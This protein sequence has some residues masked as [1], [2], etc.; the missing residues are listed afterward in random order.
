MRSRIYALRLVRRAVIAL[1]LPALSLLTGLTA[2]GRALG[3]EIET[4]K[5]ADILATLR[6]E[7][8]LKGAGETLEVVAPRGGTASG[9][10]VVRGTGLADV[11]VGLTENGKHGGPPAG[12]WRIF[13]A[14]KREQP[15]LQGWE[16]RNARKGAERAG[17]DPDAVERAL[18]RAYEPYFDTL[19]E[20]PLEKASRHFLLPPEDLLPVV[21]RVEVP[22]SVKPGAYGYV[23]SAG[24]KT[25]PVTLRVGAFTAP[26]PRD[27]TAYSGFVW[28][29]MNLSEYYEVAPWS[30]AHWRLVER[31]FE[32]LAGVGNKPLVV[33]VLAGNYL[34]EEH[35]KVRFRKEGGRYVPDFTIVERYLDLY[36]KHMGEPRPLIVHLW[37]MSI[38]GLR[39][40]HSR[41]P[42]KPLDE[43]AVPISVIGPDGALTVEKVAPP[44]ASGPDGPW[45]ALVA[46]M[47]E[48]VK[49]RGWA[50][51][52]LVLGTASDQAPRAETV[53]AFEKMAPGVRWVM[54]G[55][56]YGTFFKEHAE[57]GYWEV[58]ESGAR[59]GQVVSTWA[60][61]LSWPREDG[62]IGGWG[63]KLI[64]H[65]SMRN[66]LSYY[67][68]VSQW[69]MLPD[70]ACVT[71][72]K[73]TDEE[74]KRKA[75]M[76]W[77]TGREVPS[78][79]GFDRI[80][81]DFWLPSG[82]HMI[83]LMRK[84][85]LY[86]SEPVF[87]GIVRA[88]AP[89]LIYAG[90]DGPVPTIRYEMLREGLQECEARITIEKALVQTPET[91][92]PELRETCVTLLKARLKTMTREGR[93][94]SGGGLGS[95]ADNMEWGVAENWRAQ[96]ARL[97]ELA[98]RVQ[99]LANPKT[100]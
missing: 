57:A 99:G 33:T 80:P 55:H 88:N 90:P 30:E 1:A 87:P 3:A 62:I 63:A 10:V 52:C 23:L 14:H 59:L 84:G 100:D 50:K 15:P 17:K 22:R 73:V 9:M 16:A 77:V 19:L 97:F 43:V 81:F 39:S 24:A 26:S 66:Y 32:L 13:F 71:G 4:V 34:G 8:D 5:P 36:K 89:W 46:G 35:A 11:T 61:Y 20:R 31:E 51:D 72:G 94:N 44:H 86:E 60:P 69:R 42:A 96:T 21:V 28:S 65:T 40:K 54:F 93:W 56:R 12:A 64:T 83:S 74:G 91:L 49:A 2:T 47:G 92:P 48:L 79:G 25:V 95:G 75:N 82:R 41:Y 6:D 37:N 18:R 7:K 85:D 67:K 68:P 76:R 38:F 78:A 29:E 27:Y 45:T 70:G 53:A 98:G 58:P